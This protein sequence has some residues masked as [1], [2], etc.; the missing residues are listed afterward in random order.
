MSASAI[1][2]KAARPTALAV[3]ALLGA[4]A[5]LV[6]FC[7]D[8]RQYHFY[9]VCF[10]HRPPGCSA[11]GAAACARCTNCCTGIWRR[12]FALTRCW[13]SRCPLWL[14][15]ARGMAGR[16]RGTSPSP[17]ACAHSGCGISGGGS[18]GQR[19]AEP[20]GCAFR[21]AAAMSVTRDTAGV[22]AVR[23][24]QGVGSCMEHGRTLGAVLRSRTLRAQDGSRSALIA[25]VKPC[26]RAGV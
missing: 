7:F 10:F 4:A 21:A 17:S 3:L 8:P 19:A 25:A 15:S 14:G 20:A 6:L 24:W 5:G 23:R 16:R 11:P 9:P 13:L 12:H 26:L 1:P 18:R 2:F 22:R